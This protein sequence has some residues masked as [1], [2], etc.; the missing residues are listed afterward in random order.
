MAL[1]IYTAQHC[2][3]HEPWFPVIQP[4]Q[5]RTGQ[6]R[7]GQGRTGQ[8]RAGQGRGGQ[9]HLNNDEHCTFSLL[10]VHDYQVHSS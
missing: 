1:A 5:G 10:T 8:D 4:G 9:G 7:T 6:G 2:T 3:K